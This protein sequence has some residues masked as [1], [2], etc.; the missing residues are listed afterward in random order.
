[1]DESK[2]GKFVYLHGSQ[3]RNLLPA[4]EEALEGKEA[5]D[6]AN[7][8]IEAGNAYGQRDEDKIQRV[9]K[10]IFPQDQELQ[11]GMPFSSAT[12][13]GTAVN[14]VITAIEEEEVVVDGNHPLAGVD[15]HFD[16]E[17]MEIRDATEEE[18]EH[19]HVHGVGGHQH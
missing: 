18:I 14:V 16:I 12:A 6:S 9:P 15:L 17:I 3:K 8:V 7:V 1:M 4:L 10:K 19:G 2:D 11:V 5:G 13:D